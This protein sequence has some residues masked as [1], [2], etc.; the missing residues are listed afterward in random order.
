MMIIGIS[1]LLLLL[2]SALISGCEAAFFSLSSNETELLKSG[3]KHK[4][5]IIIKLIEI[6]DRLLATIQFTKIVINLSVLTLLMVYCVYFYDSIIAVIITLLLF[7]LIRIILQENMFKRL[8]LINPLTYARLAVYPLYVLKTIGYPFYILLIHSD[9]ELNERIMQNRYKFTLDELSDILDLNSVQSK[10]TRLIR[11]MLEFGDT[12]VK[13]IMTSRVDVTAVDEKVS[14][15]ELNRVIIDSGYSRIPV[16]KDS[17]D[18]IIGILYVKDLWPYL[19][20]EKES[21]NWQKLIRPAYFVPETKK[22][23]ELLKD[24]QKNKVHIAI[25]NDEYGGSYGIVTLEDILEEIVGEIS[26]ESD[27]EEMIV[28]KIDAFN[29]L[30]EG[31]IQLNDFFRTLE[32]N[33]EIFDDIKGDS[34]TLAGLILDIK[35]EMPVKGEVIQYKNYLFK[36]EMVDKR[37][38]KL[39]KFT[40]LPEEADEKK[41]DA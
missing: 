39:I 7:V 14:I 6:P 33:E 12:D 38:I 9:S 30:F 11:G 26:D 23:S 24:F 8:A 21:F 10:D 16:F 27:E 4:D 17:F 37:R 41:E 32:V 22:I 31:K 25:V 18:N 5:G 20:D 19:V 13:E 36:I 15:D 28:T 40:I 1:S 3:R 34:D 35:G 29:Y 2:F